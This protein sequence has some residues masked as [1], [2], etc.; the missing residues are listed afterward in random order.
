VAGKCR[1]SK[2]LSTNESLPNR[3]FVEA[4]NGSLS[5]RNVD[6]NQEGAFNIDNKSSPVRFDRDLIGGET[7][8][9]NH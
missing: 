1:I 8:D 4:G 9:I 5:Y 7:A 3:Y 2:M 6:P